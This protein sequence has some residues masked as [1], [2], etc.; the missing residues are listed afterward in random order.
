[1]GLREIIARSI[2]LF[3]SEF[4][5]EEDLGAGSFAAEHVE[6]KHRIEA[7]SSLL[8]ASRAALTEREG[9]IAEL[10]AA[11]AMREDMVL[12][13][14]AYFVQRCDGPL[15]GPFCTRCFDQ[16]QQKVRLVLA[17][18]PPGGTGRAEEWV[19]C[20]QCAVP[21]RSRRVGEYLTGRPPPASHAPEPSPGQRSAG[22]GRK[23]TRQ[24][25][26][27]RSCE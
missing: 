26:P 9:L 2:E 5:L 16:K 1:M 3:K 20:Q 7:L 19:Q 14:S 25:P 12:D 6:L 4:D 22:S 18:K 24:S 23:S 27:Q 17:P 8:A 10:Q 13:G 15:D 11:R 21:F